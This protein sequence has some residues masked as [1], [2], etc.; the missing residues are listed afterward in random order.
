METKKKLQRF[1][2]IFL[3]CVM[4]MNVPM[5]ALAFEDVQ[6]LDVVED[7][8]PVVV[9]EDSSSSEE[10][11]F[12]DEEAV[13]EI[14][15]DDTSA[16]EISAEET[17]IDE[18]PEGENPAEEEEQI[19]DN[20]SEEPVNLFNDESPELGE[21]IEI[22]TIEEVEGLDTMELA[23][24][25]EGAVTAKVSF[26]AQ[27]G[28]KFMLPPQLDLQVASDTAENYGYTDQTDS[29]TQVSTIDVLVAAHVAKYGS[30]FTKD[31]AKEEYLNA[32]GNFITVMFGENNGGNVCLLVNGR[33]PGSN[34]IEQA[35]VTDGDLVELFVYQN[36]EYKDKYVWLTLPDGTKLS[37]QSVYGGKTVEIAVK[38]Y[39]PFSYG[40]EGDEGETAIS[41]AEIYL[42]NIA[43]GD[44]TPLGF[45]T[46]DNG[47]ASI[48]VPE[49]YV[50][51]TVYLTAKGTEMA[52]TL[53]EVTIE[54]A[55]VSEA[56]NLTSLE[57]AVGRSTIDAAVE[58]EL[59][60]TFA[61]ETMEYS[62]DIL[63]YESDKNNRFVWVKVAAPEGTT[64]TAKCGKSNVTTLTS[65][66]WGI[67]QV[68]GGYFY[69]PTY[70]GPLTPGD[71][72]QV[73]ITV[74]KEGET[75]KTYT[76][77]IP[78]QPDIANK[79]LA[80]KTDLVDAI[81]FAKDTENAA[82]TV[83]AQY[84]NR[85]LENEDVITYQWY[86]NTT[87]STEGGT[88]IEGATAASYNPAVT[89][90]GTSYYYVVA[91]CKDLDSITS[92]AIAV[93]VTD[94][95]APKSV[96]IVCDHPYTIPDT[97][98]MALGGVKYIAKA[99]DT[100][101]LKA[102][103]ENGNETPVNWLN[104]SI[105]GGTLD[106]E[107]G[108]YTITNTAYSYVQVASL[109]DSSIQSEEK[110]IQVVDYSIGQYNK[111]PSVTLSEDGQ[112]FQ[113]ISTAGGID[114]Y[115]LWNYTPSAENIAELISDLSKKSARLEFTAMRPGTIEAS[116]DLDLDGDG[117][118][119][120]N[121]HTDSAVLSINGIAVEDA[122]GKLTKTYLDMGSETPAP[123]VQLK[124]LSSTENAS[125]TWT[126]ADETIATVDGNGLV[127]A[128]GVGS[129][130]VSAND[131]TYTGGI[132]VVVTSSDTPYFEQIDF[133]TTNTWGTGLSS[134]T[135]KSANFKPTM[136]EYTGLSM[137]KA[138]AGTLTMS[139]STLYNTEKYIAEAVYTDV[140]GEQQNIAV[141][142]ASVTELKNLPFETSKITINLTDKNDEKKK[143]VYTFEVTRPRDTT[144]TIAS[145]GIVFAPVDREIWKDMY[146]NKTE[147]IMYVA[148][149]DGSFA[150]YQGVSS[151]R[152]YYRTYAM[153]ALEAFQL[154]LKGA[155]AYTHIRFSVDDGATWT[156][157]GM[158]GASGVST[159]NI[160]FP[161]ETEGNNPVAKV[162]IQILDDS[163]YAANVAAEK[164][165]FA[166]S[167]PN[168][169]TVW[170]EQIPVLS[171]EC[172]ILT[173]MTDKGDWYPDFD[174]DRTSYRIVVAPNAEAPVLTFTVSEDAKVTI[175]DS[176]QSANE[177]GEY[178][179]TLTNLAQ[180]IV[181]VASDGMTSK[182]YSFGYSEKE[183]IY[184]PDKVVDFLS[185]N[186]QYINGN[187]GGYGVGPQQTLTGGLLSLGNFG[188]YVTFYLENGLTD[189]PNNTYGVDFYVNGNAFKDTSTG[190][191]LGSMEPGQVWVSQDGSTWYALAGSE[192][193][194]PSTLWNYSV[195]YKKTETGGTSWSDNYGNTDANTHGRSFA[196]PDPGIYTMNNLAKQ[197][198][199]TLTGI[200]LP[201]VNGTITGT[202][203]FNSF[204]KGG[205][206]GYVDM[207]PNGT[208]NPYLDNSN[209]GNESSGFDLAWAVDASGNPVDVSGMSFHYVK[210]V[211]A[212]NIMA[213]SAN[214]KSTEVANLVVAT[215]Q[216]SEVGVTAAPSGVTFTSGE[217]TYAFKFEEGK[218]IYEVD[219]PKGMDTATIRVDGTS[220]NDNIYINNQRVVSGNASDSFNISTD[221]QKLVRII[222]QNGEKEPVI[223]LLKIKQADKEETTA[224]YLKEIRVAED[225]DF[226]GTAST[227]IYQEGVF[228]YTVAFPA[229]LNWAFIGAVLSENAPENS[230]II[231]S[232]TNLDGEVQTSTINSQPAAMGMLFNFVEPGLTGNTVTI[233]VGAGDDTQTYE[234]VYTR[235]VALGDAVIQDAEGNALTALGELYLV[236]ENVSSVQITADSYG[237]ALKING[238]E[239][240]SGKAFSF[241][242][243]WKDGQCTVE[244]SAVHGEDT[245]SKTYVLKL[246][247]EGDTLNGTCSENVA[248]EFSGSTLTISGTGKM[249]EYDGWSTTPPW[250]PI[251]SKIET[252]IVKSGITSV[253][254]AFS[255]YENLKKVVLEE[256][257]ESIAD[258]AFSYCT[259]LQ[260][261]TLPS[262]LKTIGR[263]A[264]RNCGLTSINIP[265]SVTSVGDFAFQN[266]KS[267]ETAGIY[268]AVSKSMFAGCTALKNVVYESKAAEIP[269]QVFQG[270]AFE[271]FVIP[272]GVT[273]I[274]DYAF[275]NCTAL[276][277][278]TIPSTVTELRAT[279]FDG[280]TSLSELKISGDNFKMT[281]G[282]LY[283]GDEKV[284]I[285]CLKKIS[286]EMVIPEGVT[287]ISASLFKDCTE[288]T[289]VTFPSTLTTIGDSAFSGCSKLKSVVIPDSVTTIGINAFLACTELTEVNIPEGITTLSDAMFMR[290]T[291]LTKVT[292]PDTLT[293]IGTNAFNK[294]TSLTEMVVPDKVTTIGNNAFHSCSSLVSIK[295][296][297]SLT[298]LGMSAFNSCTSLK[299]IDIPEGVTVLGSS[300][301]ISCTALEELIIPSTVT[302][303]DG[304]ALEGTQS[305]DTICFRGS[306][307]QWAAITGQGKPADGSLKIIYYY[308]RTD[309]PFIVE[310][311]KELLCGL[312]EEAKDALVVTAKTPEEGITLKYAWYRNTENS[313]TGGTLLESN[314]S[315]DGLTSYCTP[316]T[317]EVGTS[318]YYCVLSTVSEDTTIASVSTETIKVEVIADKWN[319]K[320]TE[321]APYELSDAKDLQIL[322]DYVAAGKDTSGIFFKLTTDITLPENWKP[323]GVTID[324]TN[325]IKK[326]ANLY[327]FEGIIDGNNKTITIPEGGLPLLGY[328]KGAEVKNLNIYGKQIAGYGL[329]NNYE[330]V[331]LSGSAII[332]DNVT[333]KKGSSTL[334]SGLIGANITTNGLAGVSADFAA[335]IRNCTI[336]EGVVIGYA[337]DQAMIGS[338]A[339]RM[340]GI[341]ENCIS[342]ADVYGTDYVGGIIGTRDNAMGQCTVSGCRFM[343]TVTA[344]GAHAGGIAGGGYSNS[345][346]P[347]GVR[348]AINNCVSGG[349]ITGADKVGGILGGDTYVAQSWGEYEFKNNSFSGKV[350]VTDGTYVGGIIGFY[351]SLN[352]T[353]GIANN[354]YSS[355]CG[356]SR[357]IGFVQYV[358]TNCD[359]HETALGAVYINTEIS[360]ENCP[361]VTGCGWRTGFNRTDDPLGADADKLTTTKQN[362]EPY[363]LHLTVSGNYKTEYYMGQTFDLSGME[364]EAEW[365]DGSVTN[366]KAE[367]VTV[368]GFDTTTRGEQ[369]VRITYKDAS[370]TVSVE[371]IK[372]VKVTFSLLGDQLHDSDKDGII[373]T[374][375]AANMETWVPETIYYVDLNATVLDV[376]EEAAEDYG[377]VIVA[378]TQTQY[379]TYIEAITMNDFTLAEFDN[380]PRSGWMYTVNGI[381]PEVGVAARYVDD[382]D[383]IVF[384]YSDDY[385]E[386]ESLMYDKAEA[387]LVTDAITSIPAVGNLTAADAAAVEAARAAYNALTAE[388]K[389]LVSAETLKQLEAAEAKIAEL[390]KEAQIQQNVTA[391]TNA[392]TSL[393]SAAN[394][395]A[396]D[397]AK[398]EAARAAY[399][400]LSAAEKAKIPAETL[401]K[402]EEAEAKMKD[403]LHVHTY[404]AWTTVS[405]ATVSA[406]EVQKHTCSVCGASETKSVGSKLTPVLEVPGK[407]KSFN[408]KKGKT[409][410]F[411]VTMA[412]GDAISSVKSDK[413]KYVKVSSYDK[414]KGTV[415]LKG[416]KKGTAKITIKLTSGKTRTYT[417]KAVTGTVKTT[418]LSVSNVTNK[419]LTLAAKK[420]YNLETVVKPF[421]TTQK[422]TYKSSNKKIAKVSSSGKIT[423][424][425]PG[426]TTITVTSGSKKVKITVTVPGITNVKSS[427]S[428]KKGKTLT[429]K[430]KTYGISGKVTYT[431]SNTKI[432]TVTSKGK[433][434]GIKKGTA[435]ITIK[436]GTFTKT[437]TVKVK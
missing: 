154:S 354:Y 163:T 48:T 190:T 306:Q 176:E 76:V 65:G 264:F 84:K 63:D 16:D 314:V 53:A 127:T 239:A 213:G 182:T 368:T 136:L 184:V 369:N 104:T 323:I 232:Y 381:H 26:A 270:C 21:G 322:Y 220:E 318:Y 93:T 290:C 342:Y 170:V 396:A 35:V 347:N 105:N 42:V 185:V 161:E 376:M 315:E 97:W 168:T 2:S 141:N 291:S 120:G 44:L 3:A 337:K 398:V 296:P 425:A 130:I 116:F 361:S 79:S 319:G 341:V 262:G 210:V 243:E 20:S 204:S 407:L 346:A 359:T 75:D 19:V 231:A 186:S 146:D 193:Y 258:S 38:G 435:K 252:V 159:G 167:E 153:N 142:S 174:K 247:K 421:T 178:I 72:N 158:T 352:I 78:M 271:N 89:E 223:Y 46:G 343:G 34:G 202:D 214:E 428:V 156:Y 311:T 71:Y 230:K 384:H 403:L 345:T 162:M 91:S 199:F 47:T 242:P 266:C 189:N 332:I 309:V 289:S 344:S 307:E 420:T 134:A 429:L 43:T 121:G 169:Y 301:L 8:E 373:H 233:T 175:G 335:T 241:T 339:G 86:S 122:D 151:S 9:E 195:T 248:W 179:L 387:G 14:L 85:P 138:A 222:V 410:K 125:F 391:C 109:Y 303:I 173:A 98:A 115:T 114:T 329:V 80:W 406:A 355:E 268:G 422:I 263:S 393:P 59:T 327:A 227:N 206:F 297:K 277:S 283:S 419:K 336:E 308:G 386:E 67:V 164:D 364:F 260:E 269:Q 41:G 331:G 304:Y 74:S 246:Y 370:A 4:I 321:S 330:G 236:P 108:N 68:Q 171:A 32:D 132:K 221:S 254:A 17:P 31:T 426:K 372:G 119:D 383:D 139:A 312:N 216:G 218:Q 226:S 286:G 129:V 250:T 413:S 82:L 18:M 350:K 33:Q 272:E 430:P 225:I 90:T 155:S 40:Y 279:Q 399:N 414:K 62:T 412:N 187:G 81:Y 437:V 135:W 152:L 157:L 77:T 118:G 349:S 198:S 401:K 292:L 388:Q 25:E 363:V 278:V 356:A 36:T 66:E 380:G 275:Q 302:V 316:V 256:G 112:S 6:I 101:Q 117:I 234:L 87:A 267:M 431:S 196:W 378:D 416:V 397:K 436:A 374:L 96:R 244:I 144:K 10:V 358:D 366:P 45:T 310:Q 285:M 181:V 295:L 64:V 140:N 305:L 148:N 360:T 377:F 280:C 261:M 405:E 228:K 123:T 257:V 408:I 69:A 99:G 58:K 423:A 432:A 51:K 200:L 183:S 281:D 417:V 24:S 88:A 102:V 265:V 340:Q 273:A 394:L 180:N 194:E 219:V 313:T 325:N 22:I 188:G 333:L 404:G 207:L 126:S 294:C 209:Y 338:I 415:T 392:I 124:A 253:S 299:A 229:D 30:S 395:T 215:G 353:D 375:A 282:I 147:G 131:G 70:S 411:A 211:T 205:R 27:D 379:G 107:T 49:T 145:S 113:K 61:G 11:V 92:K 128:K 37:G 238:Q 362:T 15:P 255:G 320:G 160:T 300:V 12:I 203:N 100:L 60:P 5:S 402:L 143:T 287:T 165:G 259:N 1:L 251:Q 276:K 334:K 197:D 83:E 50:G 52:M 29:S 137:T 73:V 389:A 111:T 424:V 284:M 23:S 240:E 106:K 39:A 201:C 57:I 328:V 237:A 418:S 95:Q 177:K 351:D 400:A 103:D 371:V 274:A 13:D 133:T 212:S 150:Q 208:A 149:E 217:T 365:S 433:I 317:A 249:P 348:M 54:A 7:V 224:C 110:V 293:S 191:G 409:V 298:R 427:V 434:K 28:G 172:D 382:G 94:E 326:G 192:H 55:P 390:Q 288:L 367:E 385:T 166:D 324:G 56:C 245:V 357:G 235:K